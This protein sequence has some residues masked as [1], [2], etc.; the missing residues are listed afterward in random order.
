[1]MLHHPCRRINQERMLY[2]PHNQLCFVSRG[3][4]DYLVNDRPRRNNLHV[5]YLF[6]KLKYDGIIYENEVSE[7][8][9]S[10]T[11]FEG[12]IRGRNCYMSNYQEF[13]DYDKGLLSRLFRPVDEETARDDSTMFYLA[14]D[15]QDI[16]KEFISIFG[17]RVIT[18]EKA[19]RSSVRGIRGGLADM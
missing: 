18:T 7:L 10:G 6:Q 19:D 5:P 13:G 14:T 17:D 2:H 1:M 8:K 3:F 12:W 4:P 9:K 15:D 11:D 16:K